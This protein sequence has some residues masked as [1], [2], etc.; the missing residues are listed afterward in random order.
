MTVYFTSDLHIGHRFV[1]NLRG[2]ESVAEHD[3][4]IMSCHLSKLR[5]DDVLWVLGDLAM[6]RASQD[7]VLESLKWMP[8][9]RRLVMGN[10]DP[11]HPMHRDAWKHAPRFGTVF[12]FVAPFARVALPSG[13]RILLSHF[14]YAGDT[15]SRDEDRYTQYRLRDEGALLAHGHTHS[16]NRIT[17]ER[18]VHVGWDAW[19]RLV[20]AEELDETFDA[21][22]A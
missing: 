11:V 21:A 16:A 4:T 3:D 15:A 10:H 9:R 6:G 2:F 18:E 22:V 20:S 13:R 17:S 12:E 14:P 7:Y 19:G 5:A 1:A 8:F